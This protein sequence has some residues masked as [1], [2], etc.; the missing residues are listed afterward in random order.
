[1]VSLFGGGGATF[2][3]GDFSDLGNA[4]TGWLINGGVGIPVGEAGNVAIIG[5][6]IYGSNGIEGI[7]ASWDVFGLLGQVEYIFNPGEATPWVFGGLG[8]VS[9]GADGV[10]SEWEAALNAAAGYSVPLGQSAN[11]W[12]G[13]RYLHGFDNVTFF[14]LQAG[15]TIPLGGGGM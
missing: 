6:A 13:A 12:A 1:Q 11:G 8:A 9:L 10:D 3:T 7:D 15:I 2:P 5:E 4:E 14:N